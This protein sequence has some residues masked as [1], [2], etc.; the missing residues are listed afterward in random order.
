MTSIG[1]CA[2]DDST[3]VHDS[4]QDCPV[5]ECS[6][7]KGRRTIRSPKAAASAGVYLRHTDSKFLFPKSR[8]FISHQSTDD[9]R[10]ILITESGSAQN[11]VRIIN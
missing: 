3:S 11:K 10:S 1:D 4:D 6:A 9:D 2:E 7:V 8:E 5:A